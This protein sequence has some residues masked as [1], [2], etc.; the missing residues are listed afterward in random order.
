MIDS[1]S[2]HELTILLVE[3]DIGHAELI[4]NGLKNAGICNPIKHFVDGQDAWE[5]MEESGISNGS[6]S[7]VAYLVVLDIKMPRMD[8]VEVLRRM[9]ENPRLKNIPVIMLTTTDD[10][11]EI[12]H[13]YELGCSVYV[14]KP[15]D[16]GK[17]METLKRL[18]L[19]LQ[20]IKL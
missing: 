9:K 10:P 11:K 6:N 18:G 12:E 8:G 1:R 20:I 16:F 19:F 3:D 7:D 17:F 4:K 14:T 15:V 2:E 13:C 5:Y